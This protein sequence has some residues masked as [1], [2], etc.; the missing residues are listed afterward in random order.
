[1]SNIFNFVNITFG[2]CIFTDLSRRICIF[3]PFSQV[4]NGRNLGSFR[5]I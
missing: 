3:I 4:S 5:P 2:N 1:L